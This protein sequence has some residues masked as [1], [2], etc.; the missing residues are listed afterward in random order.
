MFNIILNCILN[1]YALRIVHCTVYNAGTHVLYILHWFFKQ[2]INKY[3]NERGPFVT[4]MGVDKK[5]LSPTESAY[6]VWVGCGLVARVAG[7]G[8]G[9]GGG[10]RWWAVLGLSFEPERKFRNT[11]GVTHKYCS[12]NFR[13]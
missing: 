7:G 8:G 12:N 9:G 3:I 2:I 5:L 6:A 11:E 10:P 1:Q 13:V 4:M